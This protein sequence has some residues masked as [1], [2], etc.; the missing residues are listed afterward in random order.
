M[1]TCAPDIALER[2]RAG[3]LNESASVAWKDHIEGCP[4]CQD[5]LRSMIEEAE[6][7]AASGD[8]NAMRARLVAAAQTAASPERK[9]AGLRR[10]VKPLGL[11]AAAAVLAGL[12][13][14]LWP[15]PE[16]EPWGLK[17]GA[18]L[19]ILVASGG[20]T[21]EHEGAPLPPGTTI[22]LV[23]TS[24]QAGFLTVRAASHDEWLVPERGESAV[25]VEVGRHPLGRAVVLDDRRLD[26]EVTFAPV[27]FARAAPPRSA[28]TST[29][30]VEVHP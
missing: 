23:W 25:R 19:S 17:G 28:V 22:Q 6:V 24:A 8:A 21:V 16:R 30:T 29:A 4:A 14:G 26:L 2:A 27:P 9:R 20:G 3:T 10:W 7:F 1:T 13:L 15:R 5:R 18:G 11:A 12:V